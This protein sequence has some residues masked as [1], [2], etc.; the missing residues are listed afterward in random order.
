MRVQARR[1]R[2]SFLT[3][4]TDQTI[5]KTVGITT[6]NS[7]L[8]TVKTSDGQSF[9]LVDNIEQLINFTAGQNYQIKLDN[10]VT[11]TVIDSIS[12]GYIGGIPDNIYSAR[13]LTKL[14]LSDNPL[15][16]L[17]SDKIGDL[18]ELDTI[19]LAFCD[20]SGQIPDSFQ[21]LIKLRLVFLSNNNLTG[22]IPNSLQQ[23]VNIVDLQLQD[24]NFSGVDL[25]DFIVNEWNIRA[26]RGAKS[27]AI[28]IQNNASGI[29]A[30]SV[31]RI[32][33][34]GTYKYQLF[35]VNPTNFQLTGDYTSNFPASS[36][37][38][39]K[40]SSDVIIANYTV[41][42]SSFDGTYTTINVSATGAETTLDFVGD[43][44][45][46]KGCTVTYTAA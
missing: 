38:N 23:A 44:F 24:N 33:G 40:D 11:T 8:Q 22:V 6:V 2:Q 1:I 30:D 36:K 15:G 14:R 28:Q 4:T 45:K 9:N 34:T 21:E 5:A 42:S 19:S 29:S 18:V 35:A 37:F 43:G 25:D 41:I 32:E 16:G 46:D 13:F 17:I 20:L 39:T 10:W 3:L 12:S 7:K 27:C 26:I 31:A